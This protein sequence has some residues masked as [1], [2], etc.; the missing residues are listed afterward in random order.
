MAAGKLEN[1][2]LTWLSMYSLLCLTQAVVQVL[3][4]AST[5]RRQAC[6]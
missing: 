3:V 1:V 2:Y 4:M 6:Y 5:Q